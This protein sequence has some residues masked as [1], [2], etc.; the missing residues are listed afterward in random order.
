MGDTTG[1]PAVGT[2]GSTVDGDS[3]GEPDGAGSSGGVS[4][5]GVVRVGRSDSS[6][7]AI[8]SGVRFD[9][10]APALSEFTMPAEFVP[11]EDTCAVSTDGGIPTSTT[12]DISGDLVFFFVAGE[13]K[14]SEVRDRYRASRVER[15][16][17]GESPVFTSPAGTFGQLDLDA[18]GGYQMPN[19]TII[20]TAPDSLVLDIPGDDFPMF[21]SVDMPVMPHLSFSDAI[22]RSSTSVFSDSS[23]S[24]KPATGLDT[25][26]ALSG[27]TR[28]PDVMPLAIVD[29]VC[30]LPDDGAFEL[31]SEIQQQVQ[32]SLSLDENVPAAFMAFALQRLNYRTIREGDTLL[33]LQSLVT[34]KQDFQ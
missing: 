27:H 15:F 6:F 26:V 33:I 8:T 14:Q 25:F 31:S 11:V 17:A 16:P 7:D 23:L 3:S 28:N 21:A 10:F 32:D 9:R 30:V 22:P 12:T 24:W 2:T 34:A 1:G 19:G 29:I 5:V 4:E 20:G 18:S 13:S